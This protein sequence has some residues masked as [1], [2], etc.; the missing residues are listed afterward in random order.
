M[1]PTWKGG[2]RLRRIYISLLF[3]RVGVAFY[4]TGYIHPDEF[5]QNGEVMAGDI[6]GL[7]TFRTWEWDA[8][9]PCRSIVAPFLTTG[10]PFYFLGYIWR[11]PLTPLT[12]FRLERFMSLCYSFVLDYCVF[13]LVPNPVLRGQALILLASSYVIHTFQVRPFSNSL[14]AVLVALSLVFLQNLLS[15]AGYVDSRNNRR[16]D[17]RWSL[18]LLAILFVLGT[19]ARL[20]FVA[21]ALP[22]AVEA[23]KWT[24]QPYSIAGRFN[25]IHLVF[26]ALLTAIFTLSIAVTADTLYFNGDLSKFV[27][28]P[29]NFLRYNISPSNLAEHG[30]HP[31]WLHAVV[32]LPMI[33]GPGVLYHTVAAAIDILYARVGEKIARTVANLLKKTCLYVVLSALAIL[34]IQPHQEPR[35]LIPLLVP[36]IVLAVQSGRITHAGKLFWSTWIASNVALAI[37]FGVLHQGGVVPSLFHLHGLIHQD[38]ETVSPA[39]VRIHY[40]NTY[41][42]PRHLLGVDE[43]D[44]LAGKVT[45]TDLAGAPPDVLLQTLVE[46]PSTADTAWL[47]APLHAVRSSSPGI[48]GCFAL[49]ERFFPHLD[50]DHISESLELGWKDGLSLGLYS[51]EV[52]CLQKA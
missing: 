10:F 45:L 37:L 29:L 51:V 2:S 6:L 42:P 47:V 15:S 9:F 52:K 38:N 46:L 20:T 27:L 24:L 35:F 7:H 48:E 49:R 34:S 16:Q 31:R 23:L 21:F 39:A 32:N 50:L 44:V 8:D 28:T 1:S 25:P 33:I 43:K 11:V 41:M 5:F 26:P 3:L 22:I 13:Q 18:A 40:W 14:E 30:L 4:S 19:F 12:L 17:G 36:C